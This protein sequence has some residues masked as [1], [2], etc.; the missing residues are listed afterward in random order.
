MS[1]QAKLKAEFFEETKAYRSIRGLEHKVWE[2]IIT[3]A[4]GVCDIHQRV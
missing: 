3:L 4:Q 1:K 2:K